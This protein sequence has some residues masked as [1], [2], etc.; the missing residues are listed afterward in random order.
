MCIIYM[1]VPYVPISLHFEYSRTRL[2][3]TAHAYVVTLWKVFTRVYPKV[4]GLAVWYK[5]GI[6]YSC[7]RLVAIVSLF[8]WVSLVRFASITV[9]VASKRVFIVV[10]YFVIGWVRKLLD[11]PSYI[12]I[13]FRHSCG[14]M[15]FKISFK[16]QAEQR[17]I[18]WLKIIIFVLNPK[19][20][21]WNNKL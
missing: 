13:S 18:Q 6:W 19:T 11:T 16:N 17:E 1:T 3:Q 7:L 15:L 21:L 14:E 4:S 12:L 9:C 8:L 20:K 5:N 2:S 10:V